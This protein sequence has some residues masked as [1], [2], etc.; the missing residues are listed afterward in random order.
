[1]IVSKQ[2]ITLLFSLLLFIGFACKPENTISNKNYKISITL[3]SSKAGKLIADNTEV[4]LVENGKTDSLKTYTHN[5]L[6]NFSFDAPESTGLEM[7]LHINESVGHQDITHVFTIKGDINLSLALEAK[8]HSV[9]VTIHTTKED[10]PI[11]NIEYT[12]NP[13]NITGETDNG[14]NKTITFTPNTNEYNEP[15]DTD[16]SFDFLASSTTKDMHYDRTIL[17]EGESNFTFDLAI[18]EYLHVFTANAASDIPGTEININDSELIAGYR[19]GGDLEPFNPLN[20][21]ISFTDER[22]EIAINLEY[23]NVDGHKNGSL[24]VPKHVGTP[25]TGEKKETAYKSYLKNDETYTVTLEGLIYPNIEQSILA[26]NQTQSLDNVQISGIVDGQSFNQTTGPSGVIDINLPVTLDIYNVPTNTSYPNYPLEVR[27]EKSGYETIDDDTKTII[28]GQTNEQLSY[29]MVEES[30]I[31]T[32]SGPVI[33]ANQTADAYDDGL[34]FI[35]KTLNDNVEHSFNVTD[36]EHIQTIS[37]SGEDYLP[38]TNIETYFTPTSATAQGKE[39]NIMTVIRSYQQ[40]VASNGSN[41]SKLATTIEDFFTPNITDDNTWVLSLNNDNDANFYGHLGI[42]Q[43]WN[44]PHDASGPRTMNINIVNRE[45]DLGTGTYGANI[46]TE[47][48]QEAYKRA[49][50]FDQSFWNRGTGLVILDVNIDDTPD[51]KTTAGHVNIFFDRT[52]GQPGNDHSQKKTTRNFT[53]DFA[54]ANTPQVPGFTGAFTEEVIQ[55]VDQIGDVG[56]NIQDLYHIDGQG[57]INLV[58]DDELV[59]NMTYVGGQAPQPT[60]K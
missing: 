27:L 22:E 58:R 26:R 50:L 54:R 24:L 31:N 19:I 3:E 16:A 51:Y 44:Y 7:I 53:Y 46:T 14:G 41:S 36:E 2:I 17:V 13:G 43:E 35:I 56:G 38:G 30:Q 21:I 15:L 12:V 6:A 37:I 11:G 25:V 8:N 48:S 59:V 60:T 9:P 32:F 40:P 49:N 34:T 39:A 1:M 20:P 33:F 28:V 29:T 42:G 45:L 5:G 10:T 18:K 23:S 55:A 47:E 4:V 57:N 52:D